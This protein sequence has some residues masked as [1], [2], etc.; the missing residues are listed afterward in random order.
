MAPG[1][2]NLPDFN[3]SNTLAQSIQTAILD[4]A[5]QTLEDAHN[6]V[7][8]KAHVSFWNRIFW[9]ISDNDENNTDFPDFATYDATALQITIP[10]EP[11]H[12]LVGG[13]G[14]V[15]PASQ[16]GKARDPASPFEITEETITFREA[17]KIV[18]DDDNPVSGSNPATGLAASIPERRSVIDLA[19][20]GSQ[21]DTYTTFINDV[22]VK[23][24]ELATKVNDSLIS[25]D[26]G[27]TST[28]P[29]PATVANDAAHDGMLTKL[30]D[31]ENNH[32]G[33]LKD[34]YSASA[35]SGSFI[36]KLVNQATFHGR[37]PG[38]TYGKLFAGGTDAESPTSPTYL[39]S[40]NGN[41]VNAA[42]LRFEEGDVF[43]F[44]YTINH[45]GSGPTPTIFRVNITLVPDSTP[46][47]A[48]DKALLNDATTID[49]LTGYQ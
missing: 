32:A 49:G 37:Q 7:L 27:V 42:A 14:N 4:P 5:T 29:T 17:D 12:A 45:S 33:G 1:L 26:A 48:E 2:F 16:G 9:V 39:N 28:T 43:A 40:T 34:F 47:Q 3:S 6:L 18:N 23:I 8:L 30:Q 36:E 11:H 46:I 15:L 38:F 35:Y 21:A 31:I 13:D 10:E 24:G 22:R 41:G 44:N 25:G 20:G 19:R